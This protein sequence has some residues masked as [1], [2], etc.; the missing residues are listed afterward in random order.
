MD[1]SSPPTLEVV[2]LAQDQIT[3]TAPD[4]T[5]PR[6]LPGKF[7]IHQIVGLSYKCHCQ[8]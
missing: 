6:K 1:N 5:A 7:Y 8:S 2:L 4:A 3:E